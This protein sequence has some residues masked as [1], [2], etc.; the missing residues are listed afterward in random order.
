MIA[1]AAAIIIVVAG[2]AWI[3]DRQAR[4]R[5]AAVPHQAAGDKW[6]TVGDRQEIAGS[7]SSEQ[8]QERKAA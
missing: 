1:V 8:E 5:L 3:L 7:Q 4:T 6:Q 2:V